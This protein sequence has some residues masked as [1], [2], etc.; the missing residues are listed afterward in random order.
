MKLFLISVISLFIF[1]ACTPAAEARYTGVSQGYAGEV[2]VEVTMQGSKIKA[3]E[4]LESS[5][6][7]GLST[8]A[9]DVMIERIIAKQGVDVDLVSGATGSSRGLL[10][11][12][13]EA[14]GKSK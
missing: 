8:Q 4:V 11:A 12:V 13:E 14:I 3:I 10:K 5:D 2:K 1:A 7:P 9:F 6:T